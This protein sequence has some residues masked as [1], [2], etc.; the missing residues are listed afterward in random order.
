MSRYVQNKDA[1][2][3]HNSQNAV[4]KQDQ[5]R[6]LCTIENCREA[7][8]LSFAGRGPVSSNQGGR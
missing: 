1:F 8:G 2:V 6:Q 7:A 5:G 4:P 3:T